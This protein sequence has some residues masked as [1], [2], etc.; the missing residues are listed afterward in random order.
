MSAPW[1]LLP[2]FRLGLARL[3]DVVALALA[4][5][6]LWSV[7]FAAGGSFSLFAAAIGVLG[8]VAASLGRTPVRTIVDGPVLMYLGLSVFSAVAHYGQY[9]PVFSR[10]R[11]TPWQPMID[12]VVLVIYFY[13]VAALLRTRRRIGTLVAAIVLAVSILG[14]QA[15]ADHVRNGLADRAF[16][17]QF[18]SQW[19]GYPE[20]GMIIAVAFPLA[21]AVVT[22]SRST[23]VAVAS[24]LVALT[25]VLDVVPLYSRGAYVCIGVTYAA[26]AAIEWWKVNSRRLAAAG[27]GLLVVVAVFVAAGRGWS[28]GEFFAASFGGYDTSKAVQSRYAIWSQTVAMIKDHPWL[29]VGPGNYASALEKSYATQAR[30]EDVHAHNMI[31]HVTA[32]R[33]IAAA[34]AF[35]LIWWRVLKHLSGSWSRSDIGM[36]AVAFSG[37]LFAFFARSLTDHFLTGLETSER[38]GFLLWTLFAAAVAVARLSSAGLARSGMPGQVSCGPPPDDAG[39]GDHLRSSTQAERSVN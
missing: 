24:S 18:V 32:E 12:T 6:F 13:G 30:P 20:I 31:L 33:G 29:G 25:L 21:L 5:I 38:M 28:I 1:F 23:I 27:L 26:L 7:F 4:G 9:P 19:S 35:L 11:E 39:R 36:L 34:A 37:A 2:T 16:N 3:V 17:Y 15:T 8:I 10:S 22:S 14:L